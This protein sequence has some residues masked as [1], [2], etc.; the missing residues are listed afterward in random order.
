MP[1]VKTAISVSEPL[2]KRVDAL[3]LEDYLK[4]GEN[5][6]LLERIKAVYSD[7]RSW[8]DDDRRWIKATS[9]LH[10]KIVEGS[11]GTTA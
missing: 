8:T 9:R 1:T 11:C 7:E 10:R 5:R 3:G 6:R 2:F 4:Q